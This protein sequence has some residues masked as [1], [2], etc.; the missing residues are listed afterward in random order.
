MKTIKLKLDKIVI[1]DELYPRNQP[2]WTA[3]LSY[4]SAMQSGAKF[5]PMSL[6]EF[7]KARRVFLKNDFC[8]F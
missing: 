6:V 1:D 5:P 8:F 3:I 4:A 7:G 2:N